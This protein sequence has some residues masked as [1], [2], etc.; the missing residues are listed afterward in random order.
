ME[1]DILR[2]YPKINVLIQ[3]VERYTVKELD[4]MRLIAEDQYIKKDFY[5]WKGGIN[6]ET[7]EP[8]N[9][10]DPRNKHLSKKYGYYNIYGRYMYL[11]DIYKIAETDMANYEKETK[12]I[13]GKLY[14]EA[15]KRDKQNRRILAIR[16]QIKELSSWSD[17]VIFEGKKYGLPHVVNDI[18]RTANCGGEIKE[19]LLRPWDGQRPI[20]E[21]YVKYQICEKCKMSYR[22]N[23]F[24]GVLT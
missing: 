2:D 12:K 5:T 4:A 21:T 6:P 8:I 19:I 14:F 9:V 11:G 18:H 13:R 7:G 16:K 3:H 20:Q 1:S 17:F 10:I 23:K 24:T 22:K 15:I